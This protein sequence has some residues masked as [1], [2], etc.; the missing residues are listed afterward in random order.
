MSNFHDVLSNLLLVI[1]DEIETQ[2]GNFIYVQ[3]NITLTYRELLN[4]LPAVF[5]SVGY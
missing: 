5:N 1:C 2:A 3:Y 4:T